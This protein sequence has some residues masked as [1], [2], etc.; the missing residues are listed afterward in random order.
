DVSLTV[1]A[2]PATPDAG[3]NGSD[4]GNGSQSGGCCNVGDHSSPAGAT[5]LVGLVGFVLGRR[6]RR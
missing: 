1:T 5:L 2:K 3:M 4:G 6:R